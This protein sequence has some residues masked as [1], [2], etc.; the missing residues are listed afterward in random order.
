MIWMSV[1]QQVEQ[2]LLCRAGSFLKGTIHPKNLKYLFS[3]PLGCV[4]LLICSERVGVSCRVLE[5]LAVED[6]SNETKHRQVLKEERRC[7]CVCVYVCVE[8]CAPESCLVNTAI[9]RQNVCVCVWCNYR[10][11]LCVCD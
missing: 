8:L 1:A 5:I 10:V 9:H 2:V 11:K 4:V 7:V 3:F 6:I